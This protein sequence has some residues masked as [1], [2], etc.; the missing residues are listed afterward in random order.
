MSKD[1]HYHIVEFINRHK[2]LISKG[3]WSKLFEE[4]RYELTKY[5]KQD[6]AL[7]LKDADIIIPIQDVFPKEKNFTHFIEDDMLIDITP[8]ITKELN[9][10]FNFEY[11]DKINY[12]F[13]K[14]LYQLTQE[15][16]FDRQL[17]K[18]YETYKNDSSP[19]DSFKYIIL[20]P[21]THGFGN[22]IPLGIKIKSR[23]MLSVTTIPYSI[24]YN[25]IDWVEGFGIGYNKEGIEKLVEERFNRLLQRL[26]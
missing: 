8:S 20:R 18:F 21:Y 13:N 2:V 6:L 25:L 23:N 24:N 4:S 15:S 14:V 3:D 9:K 5:E 17:L 22:I 16:Q 26:N 19:V 10:Q 11:K 12:P 1:I 7:L